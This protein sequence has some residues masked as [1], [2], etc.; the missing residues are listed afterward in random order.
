MAQPETA[1]L[2]GVE[3]NYSAKCHYQMQ[4]DWDFGSS[5]FNKSGYWEATGKD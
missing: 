3:E 5:W 4:E 1:W 2:V